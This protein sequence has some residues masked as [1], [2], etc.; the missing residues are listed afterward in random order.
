MRALFIGL[1]IATPVVAEDYVP[2]VENGAFMHGEHCIECHMMDNHEACILVKIVSST[3]ASSERASQRLCPSL[4]SWLVSGR[5]EGCLG[6]R[7]SDLLSILRL[8]AILR[9]RV[10]T[11]TRRLHQAS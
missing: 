4:G 9:L 7:E 10:Q 8:R 5:R 1:L 11:E 2:D 6:V 3:S